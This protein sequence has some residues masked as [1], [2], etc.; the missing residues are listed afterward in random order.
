MEPTW[1]SL[2]SHM[3]SADD[4]LSLRRRIQSSLNKLTDTNV[5]PISNE[6]ASLYRTYATGYA[7]A[8]LMAA[9]FDACASEVQALKSLVLVFG[10][11]IAALHISVGPSVGAYAIEQV[12]IRFA[13]EAVLP[14]SA[15]PSIK[16]L[17]ASA[18]EV[19]K[20]STAA[21]DS[22]SSS[23][24]SAFAGLVS[25]GA[26][27]S[28]TSASSAKL[29]NNLLLLLCH[30]YV[31][32]VAHAALV[33]DVLTLLAARLTE[34]DMELLLLALQQ[35]GFAL[36][37]DDPG[38]LR[39]II[40]AVTAAI[41]RKETQKEEGSSSNSGGAGS[42]GSSSS[43]GGGTVAVVSKRM[44]ILGELLLDL[45]NNRKKDE[46]EALLGR[47]SQLKKWLSHRA[48]TGT[49]VGA[50]A[51]EG[52]GIDRRLR[53]TWGDLM[54]ISTLG[55]WW[56]VGS[57]WAGRA[58]AGLTSA[59]AAAP[60]SSKGGSGS[61]TSKGSSSSSASDGVDDAPI[62]LSSFGGVGAGVGGA[63]ADGFVA[64]SG[65]GGGESAA[66]KAAAEND[67]KLLAL[68]AKMRMNTPTRKAVFVALMGADDA[69]SA[70]D[71]ITRLR[72]K[73]SEEREIV[74]VLVDCAGQEASYN[75]YYSLVATAL[76][77]Y[78]HSFRFT[79]QLVAWDFFKTME[80][81]EITSA[82]RIYNIAR[83]LAHLISTFSLSFAATKVLDF[84]RPTARETLFLKALIHAVLIQ[85]KRDNDVTAVFSRLGD[86]GD[87]MMLRDGLALFLHSHVDAAS[88]SATAATRPDVEADSPLRTSKGAAARI[89]LAK[90]ALDSVTAGGGGG[91]KGGKKGDIDGGLDL[92]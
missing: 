74:R 32:R 67:A 42:D 54:S 5:E 91:G 46:H 78:H 1:E 55:R 20:L 51:I 36:R 28:S 47:G 81:A 15:E 69:E 66:A 14:L 80:D 39:D 77:A 86:S 48:A 72:L 22:T 59:A 23:S 61:S 83:L 40:A 31:F 11:L 82:R 57:S 71:R 50:G 16:T 12:T 56:L 75:P 70:M 45:R 6:V 88:L 3:S 13:K 41:K 44:K 65:A 43:S 38:L 63:A 33:S 35:V 58:A 18:K 76:C 73:G 37:S 17:Q 34:L 26:G 68:A 19:A 9:V 52:A 53:I 92:Y 62:K 90:A 79:F 10:A 24:A 8:A 64:G 87:R 89:K 2:K 25:A 30:L 84:A 49:A 27:S 21:E 60:S 4:Y 7:N 85:C 29:R